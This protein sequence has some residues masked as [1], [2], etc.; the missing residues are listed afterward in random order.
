[1]ATGK[2][3]IMQTVVYWQCFTTSSWKTAFKSHV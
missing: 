2:L 1:L 3:V